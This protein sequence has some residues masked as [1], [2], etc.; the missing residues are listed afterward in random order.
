MSAF[1][2]E[3]EHIDFLVE[4]ALLL[5]AEEGEEFIWPASINE[6]EGWLQF[7]PDRT[8]DSVGMMLLSENRRSVNYRY[9]ETE[10]VPV[11]KFKSI[12]FTPEAG[13]VFKAIHCLRYQCCEHPEWPQSEAFRFLAALE[14]RWM[15][16]GKVYDGAPWAWDKVSLQARQRRVGG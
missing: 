8:P 7:G 2:V 12:G 9:S 14:S 1:V 13:E 11:Y 4:A 10:T 3:K 6:S 16:R 15:R 5:R